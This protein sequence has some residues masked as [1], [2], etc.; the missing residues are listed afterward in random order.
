MTVDMRQLKLYSTKL[1]SLLTFPPGRGLSYRP[2]VP[3]VRAMCGEEIPKRAARDRIESMI[4]R[5]CFSFR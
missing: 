5:Q 4:P 1:S 3:K 2:K